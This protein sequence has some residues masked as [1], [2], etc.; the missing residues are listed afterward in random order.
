MKRTKTKTEITVAT[1]QRITLRRP[2][3]LDAWCDACTASTPNLTAEQAAIL[4]GEETEQLYRRAEAGQIHS[5]RTPGGV[6]MICLKSL[7]AAPGSEWW[8]QF[9]AGPR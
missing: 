9:R 8:T 1:R 7:S 6:L 2:V 3:Q 4:L 5:T